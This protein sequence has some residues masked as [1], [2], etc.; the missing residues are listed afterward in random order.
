MKPCAQQQGQTVDIGTEPIDREFKACILHELFARPG[1]RVV[2]R[3]GRL[4]FQ[5]GRFEIPCERLCEPSAAGVE[6]FPARCH[7]DRAGSWDGAA[8]IA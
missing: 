1:S 8:P 7:P 2:K 6:N 3:G 5:T 4:F